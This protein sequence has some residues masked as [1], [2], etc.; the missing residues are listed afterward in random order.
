M[1]E[2]LYAVWHGLRIHLQLKIAKK[3]RPD[4]HCSDNILVDLLRKLTLALD[5]VYVLT[6]T[7][8]L[9]GRGG[10]W[11]EEPNRSGNILTAMK[12]FSKQRTKE[13]TIRIGKPEWN[14]LQ[15]I[16]ILDETE[17][18]KIS[19]ETDTESWKISD[20][21]D[22]RKTG[23]KLTPRHLMM[24]FSSTHFLASPAPTLLHSQIYETSTF[25]WR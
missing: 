15:I 14:W 8:V 24:R 16:E 6:A 13:R 3:S 9:G 7:P 2:S 22:S 11:N 20:E 5:E 25:P 4:G 21:T 23:M 1:T 19:D 17:S 10:A 18:W 12:L